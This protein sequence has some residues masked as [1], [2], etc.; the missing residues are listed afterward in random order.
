MSW[1]NTWMEKIYAVFNSK[2]CN[3]S[4]QCQGKHEPGDVYVPDETV[5]SSSE[6]PKKSSK[7]K[8][9]KTPKKRI[10]DAQKFEQF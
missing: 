1:L 6:T 9:K 10:R 5:L 8:K 4:G 3:S 2:T 7:K